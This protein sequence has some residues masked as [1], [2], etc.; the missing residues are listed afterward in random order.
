MKNC[1]NPNCSGANPQTLEF[2]YND[3]GAKDGKMAVCKACKTT[4]VYAWRENNRPVY[5]ALAVKWRAKNPDRQHA[6]DIK[7]NYGLSVEDYN[8]MLMAQGMKCAICDIQHDP[9]KKRGRLYVD[10][11]HTTG[12]IRALLCSAHNLML[13]HA[14]DQIETLEKAIAYLK[15]H[16]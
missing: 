14:K 9:S 1:K 13:G 15:K 11:C 8:K 6:A 16:Q 2:F 7:R 12:A 4:K 10:H 3:K 5:N